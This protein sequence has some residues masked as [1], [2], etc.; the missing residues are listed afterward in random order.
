MSASGLHSETRLDSGQFLAT[1][2]F[3]ASPIYLTKEI[4]FPH[5]AYFALN[6][7]TLAHSFPR[8]LPPELFFPRPVV[9]SITCMLIRGSADEFRVRSFLTWHG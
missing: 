6:L 2:A 5:C 9:S 8:N 3:K 1:R 4:H 7:S